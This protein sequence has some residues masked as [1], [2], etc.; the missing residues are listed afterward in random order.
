MKFNEEDSFSSKIIP[1]EKKV[2]PKKF[3]VSWIQIDFL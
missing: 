2:P 1:H 3:S